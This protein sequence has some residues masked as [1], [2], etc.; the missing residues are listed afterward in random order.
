MLGFKE[1]N[2]DRAFC[3]SPFGTIHS[4]HDDHIVPHFILYYP[5]SLTLHLV[6]VYMRSRREQALH[7]GVSVN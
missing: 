3:R 6:H 7:F 1:R 2:V 5:C 4:L